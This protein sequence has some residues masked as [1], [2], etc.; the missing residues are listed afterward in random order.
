MGAMG[1]QGSLTALQKAAMPALRST[2]G[3]ASVNMAGG[4]DRSP[5]IF[6]ELRSLQLFT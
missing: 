4:G 1:N 3:N 2:L 6:E 5:L